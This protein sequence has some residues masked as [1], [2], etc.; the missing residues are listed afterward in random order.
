VLCAEAIEQLIVANDPATVSAVIAE[1]VTARGCIVPGDDYWPMLRDICDRYGA[2]L[3]ADEVITGFGRTGKMFA[4]EHTGVVPDIMSVAKGIISSYLPFGATITTD[5]VADVFVGPGNQLRHVF[6]AT[7]HPV[8]SAAALKNIEIIE[9]EGLVDNSATV[10]AYFKE[11]LEGLMLDHESVGNVRGIGLLLGVEL[12][13]DRKTK[14]PFPPELDISNRLTEKLK[15]H[16]LL[17]GA[18]NST[19]NIGPPLAVT[20]AE[21]DEIMHGIDLSLWELE[22]ELGMGGRA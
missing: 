7:G 2:L 20:T 10:G 21:V 9:R 19:M 15:S 8:C 22:G 11:Q 6:T 14:E 1:P 13:S 17:L 16:G 18:L 4:M 12:V 5:E 3:V